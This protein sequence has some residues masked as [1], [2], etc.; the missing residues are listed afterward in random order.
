MCKLEERFSVLGGGS[1]PPSLAVRDALD[2]LEGRARQAAFLAD[3]LR[4]VL[5]DAG[6][7]AENETADT[8][9]RCLEDSLA[10]LQWQM[11]QAARWKPTE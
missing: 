11:G 8:A 7:L 4:D 1:T 6:T 5:D 2:T 3:A 9:L 10:V